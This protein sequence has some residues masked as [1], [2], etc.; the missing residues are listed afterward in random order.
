MTDKLNISVQVGCRPGNRIG[1]GSGRC[2][3]GGDSPH[4]S[5][6]LIS[7]TDVAGLSL[8][9]RNFIQLLALMPGRQRRPRFE[10]H[11]AQ[12][13]SVWTR[14]PNTGKYAPPTARSLDVATG[15][16]NAVTNPGTDKFHGTAYKFFRNV[17]L[18][19]KLLRMEP[20]AR[21]I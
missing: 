8:N 1:H 5:A 2:G 15:Q 14:S 20:V 21:W 16:I 12:L 7:G 19:A 17:A 13:P 3:V 18:E 9:N 10:P 6:G 11:A 4:P